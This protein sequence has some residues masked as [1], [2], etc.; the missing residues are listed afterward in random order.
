MYCGSWLVSVGQFAK[1]IEV[2]CFPDI[3]Q[4]G[5]CNKIGTEDEEQSN[6]PT[7]ATQS[8]GFRKFAS[9]NVWHC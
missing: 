5:L 2:C 9:R 1:L 3:F 6:S 7:S 4:I 8:A